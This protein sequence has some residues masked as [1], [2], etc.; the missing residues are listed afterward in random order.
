MLHPT[1]LVA[2][3]PGGALGGRQ[4]SHASCK[5]E[6]LAAGIAGSAMRNNAVD[7]QFSPNVGTVER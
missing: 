2:A 3:P 1:P 7:E 6:L 4:Q 5:F